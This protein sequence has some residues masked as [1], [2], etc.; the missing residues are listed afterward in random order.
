MRC[1]SRIP[2][3][4]FFDS[5]LNQGIHRTPEHAVASLRP[6][7]T[8]GCG[9]TRAC[10]RQAGLARGSARASPPVAR[11][12]NEGLCGRQLEGRS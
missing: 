11:L 6:Q 9:L 1:R 2:T 8:P 7:V 4:T 10:S 12:R 5:V 3:V